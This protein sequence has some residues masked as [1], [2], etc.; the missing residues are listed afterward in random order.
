[1]SNKKITYYDLR[2]EA[3]KGRLP[4]LVG[5]RDEISRINRLLGRRINNNA[6]I[7]GP[8]GIGKT[9]LAYGWVRHMIGRSRYDA[10]ALL[11]LDTEH[12]FEAV[13]DASL[14]ERYAEAFEHLPACVLFVDD[15]GRELSKNTAFAQHIHRLYKHLLARP[16]VHV[17]LALET[18]EYAWLEREYPAF[19]HL[20]E[21]ITLKEQT[22]S[23]Y[24]R[25]LS[26]K[27]PLL[28]AHHHVIVPDDALQEIVAL[29]Q[30][31]PVLGQ[32]PRSAIH[33]LDESISS[34]AAQD[35]KILTPESVMHLIEAKTGVP[36]ARM[37]QGELQGI[38][39]LADTLDKRIVD[40]KGATAKIAATLQ[41]ARLGLRNP[42]RPLGSFLLLGPSGV[43]KTETAK[44]VAEIMFGRAE[45]FTRIDMSEFQQEHSVQRLIGA[46]PGYVGYEEGGALTNAL[47]KEPHS[48]ILLDE[49]EKAHPKVFDVFLQVLDDGRLTSGQSETVDARNAIFMATSNAAVQEILAAHA[50][51]T[52][53]DNDAFVAE[54]V[55]PILAK[56]FRL[57]FINR[58][59]SILVF[60]PLTVSSLVQVAQLE[61]QKIE[62]R[63][64][65]HRVRFAIEPE[66]LEERI[67]HIADPRFGARPVKRF[68]EETCETL[69]MDSL[70]EAHTEHSYL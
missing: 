55:L 39:D 32:M 7:V 38:K 5:R 54:T 45:S 18:H 25:I 4:A 15:F 31:F 24:R 16:D 23:E 56:T 29:A 37:K 42:D 41:R 8:S 51:H 11:Q 26:K 68:V 14:E 58:F 21:T 62:K 63:L 61:I 50:R 67:R 59:D 27:I 47:R 70:L 10:Y 9:A 60:Q 12:V 57:E 36:S 17:V 20:F 66:T 30:R 19:I 44:C 33:L 49:I 13:N 40:Q 3:H 28:N 1:M 64:S 34:C 48:L 53:I 43:G 69:L 65:K 2:E 6:L 52:R 22:A 35:H 46:P